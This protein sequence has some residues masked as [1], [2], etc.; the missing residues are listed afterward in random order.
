[1]HEGV[2]VKALLQAAEAAMEHARWETLE[3]PTA[4]NARFHQGVADG[5]SF[6]VSSFDIE[7]QGFSPGVRGYDGAAASG[8]AIL[9]LT[10]ELAEKA[11][12]LAEKR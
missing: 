3:G 12:K 10:R 8:N 4:H 9:R 11:C 1:M 2:D 6:T 7:D 5:W